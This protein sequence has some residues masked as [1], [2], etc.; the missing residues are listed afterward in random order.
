MVTMSL[1]RTEQPGVAVDLAIDGMTCA[2]CVRRVERA[3]GQVPGVVSAS[4]D[5]ATEKAHVETRG[6]PTS[7]LVA[8]VARTGYRASV[9]ADDPDGAAEAELQR[10]REARGR[11]EFWHAALALALALPLVLPM[12]AMPFGHELALPAWLQFLLAA[13]VQFWLGAR[14]YRAGFAA[15][16]AGTGNMDLLV[17]LGTSAAFGLSLWNWLVA[18]HGGHALYF[19]AA[20][21]VVA[22]V[23][24][25]KWLE[26]RARRQTGAAMRALA[27]LRPTTARVLIDG[28]PTELPIAA[29]AT[30]DRVLMRPGERVPVDGEIVEGSGHLDESMVT[31]ESLPVVR[32]PGQKVI[33]GTINQD[34]A[35][36]VVTTATGAETV[37]ARI[38]RMVENAQAQKASVQRLVDRISTWFVP[39]VL[40]IAAVTAL[41]WWLAGA[42]IEPAIIHAVT[43]LVIACPCALGLA[44]PVAIVAGTGAAARAGILIRD[45]A[46]LEAA[47]AIDVV[48][49][50]KTGTLTEG[51]PELA[52]LATAA[53]QD[54]RHLL[55]L[56]AGLQAGSEHPLAGAVR[57]AAQETGLV[58]AV[59]TEVR[60]LPG[61]GLEGVVVGQRFAILSER[62]AREAG[63]DD[64]E[65]A[66]WAAAAA[67]RGQSVSWLVALPKGEALA[68]LAFG[69]RPRPEAAEAVAALRRQGLRVAMLSGD[70]PAAAAAIAAEIGIEEVH[71]GL[72]PADK[73]QAV[74][75]LRQGG[76]QVAMV[77]DGINDAPALAAADLGIAMGS[78]TDVA[79][80]SAGVTLVRPD[81]LL[82][83]A[84]LAVAKRTRRTI[85]QS[86]V[87]A[88]LYNVL[89]IPLAALGQLTPVLAGAAMALSSVSVVANAWRLS[90]WHADC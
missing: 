77:G 78:G 87:F 20:A 90:R 49:F 52:G 58:P 56:A 53:G 42:G 59:A 25:G 34:A 57:A 73:V 85:V 64:A 54:R 18:G 4:V 40:A 5:L 35:L 86:L 55:A 66:A 31:G 37:L 27:A 72:L 88:F 28:E 44:T 65:L 69:D 79:M 74:Q 61:R 11:R 45:P 7:S 76:A 48:A 47:H 15:L 46:A 10:A 67:A 50:D 8:A 82:V 2:S 13:P 68:V 22:L 70:H 41:S 63:T 19:E 21:L 17:A 24:L 62:A 75:A 33:G 3:L 26:G 43:V 89:L 12:A 83:A 81:P 84:A 9:L 23:L 51:R 60:S 80:A 30:G 39:A 36:V 32:G 14:F 1:E 29:V 6:A 16:R 71:A 38:I